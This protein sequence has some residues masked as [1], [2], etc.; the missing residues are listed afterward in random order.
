[1]LEQ[2]LRRIAKRGELQPPADRRD[3]GALP[4]TGQPQHLS[5]PA[6]STNAANPNVPQ[7]PV[8]P[9]WNAWQMAV[10][11]Y[12]AACAVRTEPL[13]LPSP[14]ARY[15]DTHAALAQ[16][17]WEGHKNTLARGMHILGPDDLVALFGPLDKQVWVQRN[18]PA[19]A[20][21]DLAWQ[22]L[23]DNLSPPGR[24][25]DAFDTTTQHHLLWFYGQAVPQAV[26]A[27]PTHMGSLALRLHRF[28]PV[29]PKALEL[30]HLALLRLLSSGPMVFSHL[31]A[32]TPAP[33]QG[34]LVADVASLYF[35]GSL[36]PVI[37][38][39]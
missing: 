18:L 1:M 29:D 25:T 22:E 19:Y 23:P 12:L 2:L 3:H 4:G 26:H 31:F 39:A 10:Q 36:V 6:R 9:T 13:V 35:T 17:L 14:F 28:P 11:D 37:P 24:E 30:R 38:K 5:F 7:A 16:L 32:N 20:A 34:H 15:G 27:L 33:D 8:S 21:H